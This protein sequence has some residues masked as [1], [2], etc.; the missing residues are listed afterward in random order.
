MKARGLGELGALRE[1]LRA[2]EREATERAARETAERARAERERRAFAEAVGPVTL[3]APS[4]RAELHAPRPQPLPRQ[5]ALDEQAALREAWSD[6]VDVESL[7]HT[8]EDLS[9]RRPG[10]GADVLARLRRGHWS[11][12]AQL[13]LHGLRRDE[14]RQALAE[15][16]VD[17]AR[18]GWRCVR[19]VHGKGLGSPGRTPV[20]KAKVQRWLVQSDAVIAFAQ[21]SGPQGGAGALVVLLAGATGKRTTPA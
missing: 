18:Q 21:A 4:L 11:I 1:L 10:V 16:I 9:Y 13:D 6:A 20:L 2:R 14:A 7:L 17:A 15:F 8:D 5:R 12:Q 3:L 19:I